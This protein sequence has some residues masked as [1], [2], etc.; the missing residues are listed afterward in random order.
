MNL[1][2]LLDE[3]FSAT[4]GHVDGSEPHPVFNTPAIGISEYK[5][6]QLA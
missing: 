6:T 5:T 1:E 3:T 2:T 4:C